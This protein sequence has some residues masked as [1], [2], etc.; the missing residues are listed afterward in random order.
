MNKIIDSLLE[1]NKGDWEETAEDI[2]MLYQIA[3]L[4][5]DDIMFEWVVVCGENDKCPEC[6]ADME[7]IAGGEEY[8][9]ESCDNILYGSPWP[10]NR[11]SGFPIRPV[12]I[13]KMN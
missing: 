2:K 7:Y 8:W 13:Y 11:W 4:K 10:K 1:Y 9:G 12:T 6:G 5:A 3:K